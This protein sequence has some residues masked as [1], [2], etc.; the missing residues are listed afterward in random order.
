MAGYLSYFAFQF[1][2]VSGFLWFVVL[3]IIIIHSFV[4]SIST[5]MYNNY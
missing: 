2:S 3:F 1:V 5:G 4:N